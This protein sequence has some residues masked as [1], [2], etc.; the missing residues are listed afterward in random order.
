[1]TSLAEAQADALRIILQELEGKGTLAEQYIQVLIAQEL[2]QNSKWVI[3]DGQTMPVINFAE[4]DSPE[5][6]P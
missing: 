2:R 6:A 5:T 4:T 1:V 3:S